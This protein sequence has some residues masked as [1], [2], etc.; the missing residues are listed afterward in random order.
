M[1]G[2]DHQ[3]VLIETEPAGAEAVTAE[4][5]RCTT[6]C[7]LNL[8]KAKDQTVWIEKAGFQPVEAALTGRRWRKGIARSLAGN[9]AFGA[10]IAVFGAAVAVY[11]EPQDGLA[12]TGAG[13]FI[14]LGGGAMADT[15]S[16]VLLKLQDSLRVVLVPDSA[17]EL[18]EPDGPGEP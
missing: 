6:P 2:D 4:G 16:G 15:D 1:A 3:I 12:L 7:E 10:A 9:L 11:G 13:L 18:G 5:E 14:A 8:Q 17:E